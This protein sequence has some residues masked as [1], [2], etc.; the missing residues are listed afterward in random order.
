MAAEVLSFQQE[1][2][3]QRITQRLSVTVIP[4]PYR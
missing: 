4:L 1:E 2:G 3:K